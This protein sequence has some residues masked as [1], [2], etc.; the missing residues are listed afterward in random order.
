MIVHTNIL[1]EKIWLRNSNITHLMYGASTKSVLNV[2]GA[3]GGQ[4]DTV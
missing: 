4:V 1:D 3:A 2:V